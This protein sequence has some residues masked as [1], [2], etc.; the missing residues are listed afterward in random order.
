MEVTERLRPGYAASWPLDRKLTLWLASLAALTALNIG[1]WIAMARSASLRSPYAEA[2]LLLSGIYVAVCGFR[3]LVPRVDLERV[4]VWDSWLS[5]IMLGRTAAT[6]AELCFALQCGLFVH[7]LA[8][9]TGTPLLAAG[10]L[11]M[12]PLALLAQ[13]LCWYAVLS[14][15]P[16]GHVI[17]ESLWSLIMLL[18]AASCGAAAFGAEAPLRVP[19]IVGCLV[20]GVGACLT[21]TLDVGM[22]VRRW[23]ERATDQ[24]LAL[25]TG[26]RDC[27]HRRL[28][29]PVW[30]VWREEVPWMTLYFSVGVWTSLAMVLLDWA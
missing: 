13:I 30:R 28:P 25:A 17:E 9:M 27:L 21:M 23:R 2:Q 4:C 11:L 12:V 19:L 22:Y 18:L 5:S 15:N 8:E 14:L 16:I 7:R 24:R 6:V 1:L 26:L 10:A 3:S 20:Y 29:T